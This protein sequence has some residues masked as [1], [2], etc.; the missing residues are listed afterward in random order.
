MGK[1]DYLSFFQSEQKITYNFSDIAHLFFL[2]YTK[3]SEQLG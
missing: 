1:Q 2:F 3:F